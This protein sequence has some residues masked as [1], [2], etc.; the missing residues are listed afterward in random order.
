[1]ANLA[2]D[3][4]QLNG[5]VHPL[6][7]I[8][9]MGKP[10]HQDVPTRRP[11]PA[12]KMHQLDGRGRPSRVAWT[13]PAIKLYGQAWRLSYACLMAGSV[14]ELYQLD[15]RLSH[16]VARTQWP[17]IILNHQTVQL[18]NARVGYSWWPSRSS[19]W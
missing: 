4:E 15:D 12:V 16:Q 5:Q 13:S 11:S 1:M 3:F 18:I 17:G 6:S 10:S 14:I 2:I 7:G 9:L 19:S 8:S